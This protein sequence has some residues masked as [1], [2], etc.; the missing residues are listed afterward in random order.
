[1]TKTGDDAEQGFLVET[2][3]LEMMRFYAENYDTLIFRDLDPKKSIETIGDKPPTCRFCKRS[4]PEVKFSKDAHVVPAFVGNKVLFS[5]YECNECNE[6]FSK[7]EDDL[8]KMTMGD[9]ALGQVPKRKGYASLKPQGKKSSFERGPNGVVIKQYMDEGVFTVDAANSQFIT[10]YDTQPFRPLGAYKALAKIAF[11]LLP[12]TELSRFEELRV[13]LRE[14]DVGSRKVYGGKAHWCYQTFIPGPSPF[15]KPIISLMRRREGVH[16]P[17]LMLF[18]AFGNWTYQIFPPC[19]AMDIALADRPIPVTP[20][21]HLYMMQPWLARGPIR[22]SELFLDQE[23][24]KSEPRVLK[25][26]FDKMERGPLPGEVAG[27]QNLPP[28]APDE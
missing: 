5:R 18:L 20:Y 23:D 16:A 22:Y 21:P 7:F 24:R 8:A 17:Y 27:A 10:T 19:P 6:R 14:S 25:M 11:T 28:Q 12:E 2:Q 9:R 26:H 15:P 1:M 3:A 13:W 4:K